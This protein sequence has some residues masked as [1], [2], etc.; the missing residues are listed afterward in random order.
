MEAAGLL[1]DGRPPEAPVPRGALLLGEG[2]IGKSV[3]VNG[4]P[5]VVEGPVASGSIVVEFGKGYGPDE[6]LGAIEL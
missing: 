4:L 1:A 6:L 5:P 3:L 2:P